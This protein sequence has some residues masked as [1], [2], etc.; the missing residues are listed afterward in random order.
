MTLCDDGHEEIC[1]EGMLCPMCIEILERGE[2]LKQLD[3]RDDEITQLQADNDELESRIY[4]LERDGD[5]S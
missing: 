5:K 3:R 2:L 1:Y 4:E